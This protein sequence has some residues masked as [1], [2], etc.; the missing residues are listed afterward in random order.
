VSSFKELGINI[1]ESKAGNQKTTCPKCSSSRRK[2]EELCLSVNVEQGL[3]NCHHCDWSG[4]I[5]KSDDSL[6]IIYDYRD[7]SNNLLYQCIRSFP[8]SFKQRRPD[9]KGGW[10]WN[11]KGIRRIPYRLPDLIASTGSVYIPGGEKDVETLIKHELTATTNSGGEGNWKPEFNKYLKDRDVVILED[12]DEKGQK[13]GKVISKSLYGTANSIK[14]IRFNELTK[15]SDVSDFLK[16]NTIEDLLEKAEKSSLYTGSYS[17]YFKEDQS[18][19]NTEYDNQSSD[20]DDEKGKTQAQLLIDFTPGW[21]LFHTPD[22]ELFITFPKDGHEETHPIKSKAVRSLLIGLFFH[23]YKKPPTNNALSEALSLLEAQAQFCNKEHR[24]FN[25]IADLKGNLYL[26]LCNKHWEVVEITP[27][28]WSIIPNSP[29][30]FVRSRAMDP[31][32][33]PLQGGSID[34]LKYFINLPDDQMKLI[35]GFLISCLRTKGPFPILCIQGEQGSGKSFFCRL[36]KTLIDPSKALLKTLPSNERDLVITAKN[37]WVLAFDN[38]SGLKHWISDA[39]CRLSTGGGFATRELYTDADE[40]IFDSQRAQILNGID[41]I[42]VRADL[43][44]RSLLISLPVI[45]QNKRKDEESILKQFEKVRPSILGGLLDAVSIALKNIDIVKLRKMPRMADFAKW[46]TAAEPGFG[47]EPGS[48][49]TMYN[50][51]SSATIGIGLESD[52]IA[53][54]IIDLQKDIG[55]WEGTATE[56]LDVLENKTSDKILKSKQWPKVAQT[57]SNRLRRLAPVL[58][59]VGIELELGIRKGKERKRIISIRKYEENTGPTGL[60]V[61]QDDNPY[62]NKELFA[63]DAVSIGEQEDDV[64]NNHSDRS[65]DGISFEIKEETETDDVDDDSQTTSE[66]G[67]TWSTTI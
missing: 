18:E 7:E 12:N 27:S 4:S 64:V 38:L 5:N 14:I 22:D 37:S 54:A 30:K 29:V 25:R 11:L 55:K 8:K 9:G 36:L 47:W 40:V 44:D 59:E 31:L 53:Q 34:E 17:K 51:N 58:R 26:D 2:K 56:L 24:V 35:L 67:T 16:N 46:V 62:K 19:T 41:D 50:E 20:F 49:M 23:R 13:H 6:E 43:R 42:A 39:L 28:G 32:P 60:I 61:R 21:E 65:A 3:F 63:N 10:I 66:S 48:F 15:G 45:P 33:H 57:L 1:D 52:P